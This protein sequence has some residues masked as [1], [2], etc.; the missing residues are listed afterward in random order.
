MVLNQNSLYKKNNIFFWIFDLDNTIY[1]SN[2]K[3][4]P[5]V[6]EKIGLFVANYLN[7]DINEAQKIQ[8]KF[9]E[10][11]K[12]TLRGL[13]YEF[14]MKPD[15]F[16]DFVHD[17]DYS[18]LKNDDEFNVILNQLDGEKYIYTNGSTKHAQNVLEYMNISKHFSG[19]F[20]IKDADFE[21]KPDMESMKS[22]INKFSIKPKNALMAE[23]MS[24]N[25]EPAHKL[26]IKTLLINTEYS[27][28]KEKKIDYVDFQSND[29]QIWLKD[30]IKN[31]F[32]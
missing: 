27:W 2:L 15:D 25:L 29:L 21:P 28:N 23:D 4:F 12:S 13:M 1:R 17:I 10:K 8:K 20:D 24:I 11:Y 19:I 22:F 30:F 32:D 16:L 6:Q 18:I 26:G 7:L 14:K 3:L 31:K 9:F 5:Q